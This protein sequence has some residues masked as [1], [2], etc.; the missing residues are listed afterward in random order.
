MV[1]DRD[2]R[3]LPDWADGSRDRGKEREDAGSVEQNGARASGY[4]TLLFTL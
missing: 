4:E 3:L 1:T 2:G